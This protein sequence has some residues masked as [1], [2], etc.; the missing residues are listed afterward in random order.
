MQFF[1]T[2]KHTNLLRN[3]ARKSCILIACTNSY[4]YAPKHIKTL[5][6][7]VGEKIDQK[8]LKIGIWDSDW[9]L[10]FEVFPF[11]RRIAF[12]NIRS[13]S[14]LMD[15]SVDPCKCESSI[16]LDMMPYFDPCFL[17]TKCSTLPKASCA[18]C[19]GV[20]LWYICFLVFSSIAVKVTKSFYEYKA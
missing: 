1:C 3:L 10:F 20:S 6:W 15:V 12:E 17:R 16:K 19:L 18:K 4:L 7:G 2:Q 13:R 5:R 14:W 9:L 11:Q 8:S